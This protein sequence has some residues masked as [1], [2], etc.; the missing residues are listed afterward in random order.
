MNTE[1]LTQSSSLIVVMSCRAFPRAPAFLIPYENNEQ[2]HRHRPRQAS[3]RL[4][5][6]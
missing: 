6:W 2:I 5:R 4:G 3:H 1:T